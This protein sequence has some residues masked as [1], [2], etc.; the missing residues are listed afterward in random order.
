MVN[1]ILLTVLATEPLNNLRVVKNRILQLKCSLLLLATTCKNLNLYTV[2]TNENQ[3]NPDRYSY[4]PKG[5]HSPLIYLQ[6]HSEEV[7]KKSS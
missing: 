2:V 5:M 7:C 1:T 6:H 4:L 3:R